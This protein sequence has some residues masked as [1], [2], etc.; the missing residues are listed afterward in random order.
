MFLLFLSI[1]LNTVTWRGE[2]IFYSLM[3][4]FFVKQIPTINQNNKT[5]YK[6]VIYRVSVTFTG[7]AEYSGYFGGKI[8]FY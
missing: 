5:L 4:K 8:Y 3:M 6:T 1:K 2:F 7:G